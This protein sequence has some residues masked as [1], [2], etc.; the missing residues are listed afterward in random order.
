MMKLADAHTAPVIACAF[1]GQEHLLS[2]NLDGKILHWRISADGRLAYA[3]TFRP[4]DG[5]PVADLVCA[6]DAVWALQGA[7]L[8]GWRLAD[9]GSLS[10]TPL[11]PVTLPT[12]AELLAHRAGPLG[13][14]LVVASET[15][16]Q[17]TLPESVIE[18]VDVAPDGQHV[19]AVVDGR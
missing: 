18:S 17:G 3:A 14:H 10:P 7:R 5:Q 8:L 1:G 9:G 16:A 12:P 6:G 4:A 15:Q 13:V 11:P 19:L 2:A